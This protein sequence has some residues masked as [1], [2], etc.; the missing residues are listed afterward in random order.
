MKKIT[1]KMMETFSD[2]LL[3]MAISSS[4]FT[5]FPVIKDRYQ[6]AID[7]FDELKAFLLKVIEDHIEKN[8]YTNEIEPHVTLVMLKLI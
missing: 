7:L 8:D 5:G 4:F 2:P 1:E 3:N 6:R